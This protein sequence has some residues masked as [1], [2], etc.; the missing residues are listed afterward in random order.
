M[1]PTQKVPPKSTMDLEKM[2]YSFLQR[3]FPHNLIRPVRLDLYN[4]FDKLL[5]KT[6]GFNDD[7]QNLPENCEAL[8]DFSEK[9]IIL[10]VRTHDLLGMGDTRSRFTLSHE[11]GH[12]ILHNNY[13]TDSSHLNRFSG[14]LYRGQIESFVC[15]EWQA[16]G[17]GAGIQM[18]ANHMIDL[19]QQNCSVEELKRL[20][21]VGH[22]TAT[23][24]RNVIIKNEFEIRRMI[25]ERAL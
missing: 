8:T 24:R 3:N 25:N 5:Y 6:T 7:I 1:Q 13:M 23:I 2:A 9:S 10:S 19:I 17:F 20:F 18:P 12:A 11:I 16:D 4:I 14:I 21:L 15:S 22:D